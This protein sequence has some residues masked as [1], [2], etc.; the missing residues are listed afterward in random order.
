MA[1]FRISG[2]GIIDDETGEPVS[3][4]QFN[5]LAS[6][7]QK[8]QL[9][10]DLISRGMMTNQRGEMGANELVEA[11]RQLDEGFA[12][13]PT[14]RMASASAP[15][16]KPTGTPTRTTP[17]SLQEFIKLAV[18][19]N[20]NVP[21]R[22][23]SRYW[24]EHYGHVD[25]K[26]LPS[27]EAFLPAAKEKNPNRPDRELTAYWQDHYGALGAPEKNPPDKPWYDDA[28][29]VGRQIV[30]GAVVDL[31]KM[32]GQAMQALSPDG[33]SVGEYGKE[34]QASAKLREA[35]WQPDMEGRGS[36][37]DAF[38][39][40][41]RSIAPSLATVAAYLNPA[42]EVLGPVA[43]VALFGGSQYQEEYDKVKAAGGTD[44]DARN[45]GLITGAI[46]G[47]GEVIANKL[48]LGVFGVGKGTVAKAGIKGVIGQATDKSILKPWAKATGAAM[49]GE[50][51]TEV[52][53]DVGTSAVERSYGLETPSLLDTAK[54]SGT[55]ALAMTV[56]LSPLGLAGHYKNS[57]RAQAI[58]QMLADPTAGKPE[59]RQTVVQM[60]HDEAST[61]KVPDA[62][63]WLRQ[64]TED[65]KAGRPVRREVAPPP[66]ALRAPTSAPFRTDTLFES[67]PV[68]LPPALAPFEAV[69]F[70]A[71]QPIGGQPMGTPAPTVRDILT[72][73]S[74][75]EAI[76]SAGGLLNAASAPFVNPTEKR[77]SETDLPLLPMPE[78]TT[79]PVIQPGQAFAPRTEPSV[80]PRDA[81]AAERVKM[82]AM[83]QEN[84][85]RLSRGM[86][87]LKNAPAGM[88]WASLAIG[89]RPAPSASPEPVAHAES[90]LLS[91]VDKSYP[92]VEQVRIV[93]AANDVSP[94]VLDS[95]AQMVT[96]KNSL[97]DLS[98]AELQKLAARFAAINPS[99]MEHPKVQ[100]SGDLFQ[101]EPATVP[102]PVSQA[103]KIPRSELA[104][105]QNAGLL[106]M[107]ERAD[108]D[109]ALMQGEPKQSL[110]E[111]LQSHGGM[112]DQGGE[113]SHLGVD[114]DL[115]PFQKKL[116][117]DGGL[118]L[119]EAAELAHDSGL[120]PKRDI[121]RL[122]AMIDAEHRAGDRTADW[123]KQATTGKNKMTRERVDIAV[124]KIIADKGRD[125][126][127]D[128]E[129]IKTILMQDAEFATSPHRPTT[130]EGWTSLV[131]AATAMPSQPDTLESGNALAA[132]PSP[133]GL[134]PQPSPGTAPIDA[135]LIPKSKRVQQEVAKAKQGKAEGLQAPTAES[136]SDAILRNAESLSDLVKSE[137]FKSQ[138]FGSLDAPRQR[139]VFKSVFLVAQDLEIRK[140]I[141]SLIPV[142]MMN[143]L[144][145]KQLT[146]DRLL[147]EQS[148]L[149]NSLP[150]D[151][152]N[153]V[154][155]SVDEASSLVRISAQVAAKALGIPSTL[156]PENEPAM[157]ARKVNPSGNA[158]G[159]GVEAGTTTKL[160][161]SIASRGEDDSAS[162]ANDFSL[163]PHD[164]SSV[165]RPKRNEQTE[166]A[167]PREVI[168]S[169]PI[170]G[171]EATHE[172]APL[173]SK[174]AQEQEAEQ[175]SLLDTSAHE[176]AT[177]PNNE[178]PE[179]TKA[180]KD[181]GNYKKGHITIA[182]LDI[183]IES[184]EG[185]TR[186][187][188]DK[189]GNRWSVTMEDHYGYIL[190]TV[191]KDKDH[192]DVFIKPGTPEDYM[193]QVFV[194]DQMK[195]GT[196]T[197][198]E[199]KIVLGAKDSREAREI[200]QRN[201]AAGWKGLGSLSTFTMGQF[202]TW[203]EKGDHTKTA[204]S[205]S[206]S[207]QTEKSKVE[208]M[209]PDE[210]KYQALADA[211]QKLDLRT[212][213]DQGH[214]TKLSESHLLALREYLRQAGNAPAGLSESLM[215]E[216]KVLKGAFVRALQSAQ[217]PDQ[218]DAIKALLSGR[219][220]KLPDVPSDD[221]TAADKLTSVA[222][223]IKVAKY[224]EGQL[225][226]QNAFTIADLY[227]QADQ[228]FGGTQAEGAYTP[229][230]AA[231]AIELGVNRYILDGLYQTLP[232]DPM[233]SLTK[234]R[235]AVDQ[236]RRQILDKIPAQQNR[237]TE[238]QD[239]FQQFSTP[240]DLA[241]VMAMAAN[242]SPND[243][244]LEPSA[245]LGG[246][247]VF[248]K[249]EG[250]TVYANE[251]SK[252]RADILETLPFEKVFVEN[253]EQ[254][255][256]ILPAS[257][258]PTVVLMNPPFSSTAGRIPGERKSSNSIAHLEQ[259]LKRLAPG[260]RLVALIGKGKEA[261]GG[262]TSKAVEAWIHA[263]GKVLLARIGVSGKGYK[264]YGTTYDNQI[265]VFDKIA[266][267]GQ[268]AVIANVED[269]RDAIPLLKEVRDA[270]VHS[271][272]QP[273]ADQSGSEAAARP[274]QGAHRPG[275]P[276]SP[277]TDSLG[278]RPAQGAR[279]DRGSGSPSS[280]GG[281]GAQS[282][283][284]SATGGADVSH[285]DTRPGGRGEQSQLGESV[286]EG[287][288]GSRMAGDR[289]PGSS[290]ENGVGRV[291]TER[292][293]PARATAEAVEPGLDP[294]DVG[295]LTDAVYET[296]RPKKLKIQGAKPHPGEL[297]ESAAMNAVDAPDIT[298]Q[299]DIPQGLITDGSVSIAQME[300]VVAAGQ[301]HEKILPSGVRQGFF[302]GDGTGVGKGR[303]ISTIILD[304][305]RQ[306]RKKA[307]WVSMKPDLIADAKRDWSGIHQNPD[308]I[309]GTTSAKEPIANANGILFTTYA[310][311]YQGTEAD[312]G[313][314]LSSRLDKKGDGTGR[315][316]SR[317][318]QIVNWLGKDFEG[319]IAFDE[320]HAM[321]NASPD[322]G[323]G[324][325]RG[326]AKEASLTG[327]VGLELQKRIP[328]ARIVYVSATGATE[329]ANLAYAERLGMWGTGTA[330]AD[331]NT[332]IGKMKEGGLAAMELVAQNLKAMGLY[333][334]RQL[335]FRGVT[336]DKLEHQ[337][338]DKQRVM[339]DEIA[340]AWQLVFRNMDAALK[341]TGGNENARTKGAARGRFWSTQ[342][343]FYN[344]LLTS[345]LMPSVLADVQK[346]LD[347]GHAVVLQLVNTNEA[348][349]KRTRA[350][351]KQ[352]GLDMDSLDL[353][354]KRMLLRMLL[355][356]VDKAFPT[357][358]FEQVMDADGKV[359]SQ[360]VV[361]SQGSPVESAE[362]V[363][364]KDALLRK[365]ADLNVPEGALEQL[366]DTFGEKMVAEVTG[367]QTRD[368][369]VTDAD[370]NI[371]KVSQTG[372]S[373]KMRQADAKAFMD[374][375]KQVLVF[376]AAGGT[377]MSYHADLSAKNQRKRIH[378]LI[379]PG[380]RAD[381]AVQGFGRTHRSSQK[382]PP[383][384]ILATTDLKGHKRFISSVARRLNQLGAL[385]KGQRQT[386][387][388]GFFSEE[389]NLEGPYAAG[390]MRALFMDLFRGRIEGMG[391]TD[392][393]EQRMG[394]DNL[395]DKRT[396]TL[397]DEKIPKLTQ[398]MNRILSL[399]VN[400]QNQMFD[401]FHDRMRRAIELAASKGELD[402]GMETLDAAGVTFS[403]EET[404]YI[405]PESQSK[406]KLL[407]FEVT[408]NISFVPF[409]EAQ[410]FQKLVGFVVGKKSG[411]VFAEV[412]PG[413]TSTDKAGE[414]HTDITLRS[415]VHWK[416]VYTIKEKVDKNYEP[417]D[418]AIARAKW[419]EQIKSADPTYTETIHLLSG[420][421]LPIWDRL[422]DGL[423]R[424]MRVQD[425]NGRR[426]IGRIIEDK[427]LGDMKKRLGVESE[428]EAF[429]PE[430]AIAALNAK[431]M[432]SYIVLSND[433]KIYRRRVNQE[434]R[435]ELAGKELSASWPELSKAGVFSE[436]INYSPRYF[437]PSG[438]AAD[439]LENL[440][441][442]RKIVDVLGEKDKEPTETQG[443]TD[444]EE[445]ISSAQVEKAGPTFAQRQ[446]NL[447]PMPEEAQAVQ[448]GI[449]GKTPLEAAQFLSAH[450][451][452]QSYR[453]IAQRVA[454]QIQHLQRAGMKF[455]LKVYHLG[456]MAP[457]V[458]AGSRAINARKFGSNVSILSFNGTDVTGKVGTSY[459]AVLHELIHA[460]TQTAV[461][462]G[463]R[464]LSAGTPI[465]K[466]GDEL[467]ALNNAVVQHFNQ[468][469]DEKA[470]LTTFEKKVHAG[471]NNALSN[472]DELL[473]WGLTN[474]EMQAFMESIPYKASTLWN[475]FVD[476]IRRFLGLSAKADTALSEILRIGD[477]LLSAPAQSYA[478]M[479]SEARLP[480]TA[481]LPGEM[482]QAHTDEGIS[483]A[484]TD[485]GMIDK[486]EA[487]SRLAAATTSARPY[488]LGSLGLHQLATV[489]GKD[490]KE[491]ANY[492]RA[493]QQMEADFVE[494]TRE[495]DE[496]LK[497]WDK[498]KVNV[499]DRMA[500]VMEQARF[501]NYDPDPL[502]NTGAP[503]KAAEQ[504][505]RAAFN[506]LPDE[507]K[508]VYR[509]ARDFYGKLA[510]RRFE[511]IAARIDRAGGTPDNRKAALDKLRLAYDQVRAKVYF[512]F[513]RFG[514]HIVVARK[515]V[516][517]IEQDREVSAFESPLEA[518]QFATLM[519]ARGWKVKQTMAKE[520]SR[521]SEGAAS[522]AVREILNVVN[523]ID[524]TTDS[525]HQLLDAIN[526]TFI[527][528]LP[529][530]SYAKHFTHAKDVKGFSKDA[531]RAF[532]HS[533]MHGAHH[534]SRIQNADH[535][536]RALATMDE[537]I[538][539]TDEGDVTEARQV[540]NELTK[541]HNQ[542]LDPN[543]SPVA[544]WLGQLGFTM[545]LGGVVATGITNATQ[546]PLVTFPWLGSRYGFGKAGAALGRAYK[547][548]L[549]P[550]TLNADSLFDA[551]Q[552]KRVTEGER[553]MLKE[554]Q[555]RGRI[556][557]TQTMDLSGRASQDNLSRVAKQHGSMQDRIA[558]MLGFT[559]HA[560]EVM[561]RQVT[562]LATY[563]MEITRNEPNET[564][565]A[566]QARAINQA[567]TAIID[568][569]FIYTCVDTETECL[570]E[571]GWKRYDQIKA[572]DKVYGVDDAGKLIETYVQAMNIHPGEHKVLSIGNV[573]GFS[574]VAT[575]NH[576]CVVQNYNSRDKK[577]QTPLKRMAADLRPNNYIVRVPLGGDLPR[578]Q[579]YSDDFVALLSWVLAE[580]S[581]HKHRNCKTKRNVRIVQSV[582]HNPKY[583][584]EIEGILR[585]LGG[586][587]KRY[588]QK[589]KTDH[590]AMFSLRMPLST[591]VLDAIPDKEITAELVGRFTTEQM[592]LFLDAFVRADGHI[593]KPRCGGSV[594]AEGV[595]LA[596]GSV[597]TQKLTSN[598]DLLQMMATLTGRSSSIYPRSK[599]D[600]SALYLANQTKR[601]TVK[602]MAVER[603][604]VD[605]VWCP[606]TT[607]G[608]WIARRNGRV[609][610]TGN[611]ENRPRY[612][613]GNVM[614]VLTMFKQY[615][616][617]IA[618]LY[619][620]SAQLWLTKNQATAEE[621]A[622]AK[623]QLLSMAGLQFAAAGALG[624]PF[625]GTVASLFTAILNGFG[626]DD[627]KKDWEVELRKILAESFGKEAGEVLSHGASRLTPWDMS[628]R[629][630]QADLFFMAPQREREGR[631]AAM[632]WVTS[633]SGP[634]LG[635]A[636]NAYL[637]VGDITKGI[638]SA[639][640]GHFLRGVEEM[641]PAVIRN[642]V[643]AL[644]YE[645][646]DGIKTR[647]GHTQLDLDGAE[648][649]GQF[650]GFA[651]SRGAEMY[652]SANA[653]KN[654]ERHIAQARAGLLDDYA[655]AYETRDEDGKQAVIADVRAFNAKH[656]EL[657]ING[658]TL[659]R[660]LK[661]R[662]RRE[663]GTVGGVY[664]PKK[665]EGLRQEG[666]F[667]NY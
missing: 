120:I 487:G 62:D 494:I 349:A 585:R 40:G 228:A 561:N 602:K 239:E 1:E 196:K 451:P 230:D 250:A 618:F 372:R 496:I 527:N 509:E 186:S 88:D 311:L 214:G 119:D 371:T 540:H 281:R 16:M 19:A 508:A 218:S 82:L 172:E 409:E 631:A 215:S 379:Q 291:P 519:K 59:E 31:P 651:P 486:L 325:G 571:E 127:K 472:P 277:A 118:T 641:T 455:E 110:R 612:M 232:D 597:I 478:G 402:T 387:G 440:T 236:I 633:L 663:Q 189:S 154:A 70:K 74:I 655:R 341:A 324:G 583:V 94:Q 274:S 20:P 397:L 107:A 125:T 206:P 596:G 460:V 473:A 213:S 560:P 109:L 426:W 305:F 124:A 140:A 192:I 434:L 270:R 279:P 373:H 195:S 479:A 544:A 442:Y 611:S 369:R 415:T 577:W 219:D 556:D 63:R 307:L 558:K 64:A 365:L 302:V 624:M 83:K 211:M 81:I 457:G 523:G 462:V 427:D 649:L 392:L 263:P 84:A 435:Y 516:D 395:V 399:E 447:D 7:A 222:A 243:T 331:R 254:L 321:G 121:N 85:D 463:T 137:P 34:L 47:G 573:H 563:R 587:Y 23:L 312:R 520:Y 5:D 25:P 368:I 567:E 18:P 53:Q 246:I 340:R 501:A 528:S 407:D 12:D 603:I 454:E 72:A 423:M 326:G 245:G 493:S 117:R 355:E 152:S 313:G 559:F 656:R 589:R 490:H 531:L 425:D 179:P 58:D 408:H 517:G 465:G 471:L 66:D 367:R 6:P 658:D 114:S 588:D 97:D 29:E 350:D 338:T 441:Q 557:L 184:P 173:F 640:S 614:R 401:A 229:K 46:Q 418:T 342:L 445:G 249:N 546:V 613:S 533:A 477:A 294:S 356:Y 282:R 71:D 580:G 607:C 476:T 180:Q 443:A 438:R 35:G 157:G 381:G 432:G 165:P 364:M 26:T 535:L 67:Q 430:S 632:D 76:L 646:E 207:L 354:P 555:R 594:I 319:V 61:L 662:M 293:A 160:G 582:S 209:R 4:A 481:S 264:K 320:A 448:A 15:A 495:S 50:P 647:D 488:L 644:R 474:P 69:P 265:L 37:A 146:P 221:G 590:M 444:D 257:V 39:R 511:A 352:A 133:E 260:G 175:A 642:G 530:M 410:K 304:N 333:L 253:A 592:R 466:L 404:V 450:A 10:R 416:S 123:Y 255:N 111:F 394:L 659:M 411:K 393:V 75:D 512:P 89:T 45:A 615:G 376:S 318:D 159:H 199:H 271:S 200:Y 601:S 468:R 498:L 550:A 374:D 661:G 413:T 138:G 537:R 461:Y 572:G 344:Q 339:Y 459:Q 314:A 346:R 452:S 48:T 9:E 504:A 49:V 521:D 586:H 295:D 433:W 422:P 322:S 247:A 652:E 30:A 280:P 113:L 581:Y 286:G 292:D 484:Q 112:Q 17:P 2:T 197:F 41:G 518:Q 643:K 272:P 529:D 131:H 543:T 303:E 42:G 309:F 424:V 622:I 377:G 545:S 419:R 654:L 626:D 593:M 657:A 421:M 240:P 212:A 101:S 288:E 650:F 278:A 8:A 258:K 33:S 584:A 132:P 150:S 233:G 405:H 178:R 234:A 122:I 141:V 330:F 296:Y 575:E 148:M 480:I 190:G 54:D 513:T 44:A 27:L 169:R 220:G 299:P 289:R 143:D 188:T 610:V 38:I 403:K 664:L 335:S 36:V 503:E 570:T 269:V 554:L 237:R 185:S 482:V 183:S 630:G 276:L 500:R 542:I 181:A 576:K 22:E 285:D 162:D 147:N 608:T 534:I 252:R 166:I 297:V 428:G 548:F 634:V 609:F 353:T 660:S 502:V 103:A 130:A 129:R 73:G 483:N 565:G 98:P 298:Y 629:L 539:Q 568:T 396:G 96:G 327:L 524:E 380:W 92:T 653:V 329:V 625:V 287:T 370:G 417:V 375:K 151:R 386:G 155:L 456:D 267:T 87:T 52:A 205:Y 345:M 93:A 210:R 310:G 60:L 182:G 164:R 201:Y 620:R 198:D 268:A 216:L 242:I 414:V 347:Q 541:R 362:A 536:T 549:D 251:Y 667:A 244:V 506:G 446:A 104:P 363:A 231:D 65:V 57:Q 139:A 116:I 51:V 491:V 378:Y 90:P 24:N 13:K 80:D 449:E 648:K 273:T 553:A 306:G 11:D 78:A 390:A 284:A 227:A 290:V 95:M 436:R 562:A 136:H 366:L 429:T 538:N 510:D 14:A 43:T 28:K 68:E 635:Y 617:N 204:V 591:Q 464:H 391:W 566:K 149:L 636:V 507:A 406:T 203:L 551:S 475:A 100:P 134:A 202:K 639:D 485:T 328:L 158:L 108:H 382:Q 439:V 623:T 256:N 525:K 453:E 437:I 323:D 224:V 168:G 193:G 225:K 505:V 102:L 388:Q 128:V 337:L 77:P 564:P 194:I 497:H 578:Q 599:H 315:V 598:I 135:K 259:A 343:G 275:Q 3:P 637:G 616:Q 526:Q 32:A 532:A 385:T 627:D 467:I 145:L 301:A 499:A 187:G 420:T 156:S 21:V 217:Q 552:S 332:F 283:P 619:G 86:D 177:S 469:I 248:A 547:D 171:R 628:A 153:H 105:E 226:G 167:I 357:Q 79:P 638:K 261:M 359:T 458:L 142:Y 235:M 238:E 574:M 316:A 106:D 99:A 174:S 400:E 56:I 91:N 645:M 336:Y 300:A 161:D 489:Y 115:Q 604:V 163:V 470:E 522:K 595:A 126:G 389:D 191:G 605:T 170:I 348:L 317:L 569:H 431:S 398:F 384:Y 208:A 308:Q 606:T 600:F 241:F 515:L 334:A 144:R 665:R 361:D 262:E 621:K 223:S 360:P 55:A 514:D 412:R 266:S 666:A 351:D 383:E 176:A 358:Q 579:V 492:N